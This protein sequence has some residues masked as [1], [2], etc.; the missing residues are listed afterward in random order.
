[1]YDVP[2]KQFTQKST[3]RKKKAK[4]THTHK[5]RIGSLRDVLLTHIHTERKKIFSKHIILI[6]S[7]LIHSQIKKEREYK[8]LFFHII[9]LFPIRVAT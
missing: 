6:I 8:S 1:M 2:K 4:K 9:F 3:N 5:H 7:L